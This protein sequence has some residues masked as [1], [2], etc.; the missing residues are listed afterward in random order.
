MKPD[1]CLNTCAHAQMPIHRLSTVCKSKQHRQE[2]NADKLPCKDLHVWRVVHQV[3]FVDKDAILDRNS[4][5][6]ECKQCN[7][8][9]YRRRHNW[10]GY[11]RLTS[12]TCQ[13][14]Q[15]NKRAKQGWH[16]VCLEVD[17]HD[18]PKE[19]LRQAAWLVWL[20]RRVRT[21][22]LEVV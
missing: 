14:N 18:G 12:P 13:Q 11:H 5:P 4:H 9:E 20:A 19:F 2:R 3:D 17:L 6:D 22:Q 8:H 1:I 10:P 7:Q 15:Q 16:D 21:D